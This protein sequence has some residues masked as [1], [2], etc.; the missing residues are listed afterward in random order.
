MATRESPRPG[1]RSTVRTACDRCHETK[2][3]CARAA[4][5]LECE[6]CSRLGNVCIY[7]PPL[8]MGRPK[9]KEVISNTASKEYKNGCPPETRTKRKRHNRA[10][11]TTY[12]SAQLEYDHGRTTSPCSSTSS[13][14]KI[15]LPVVPVEGRTSYAVLYSLL[16]TK[17]IHLTDLTSSI[18]EPWLNA[19]WPSSGLDLDY[20]MHLTASSTSA[21]IDPIAISA[22]AFDQFQGT[23]LDTVPTP[24][25]MN[26]SANGTWGVPSNLINTSEDSF[27]EAIEQHSRRTEDTYNDCLHQLLKLQ[28]DLYQITSCAPNPDSCS[29]PLSANRVS[30][31][32]D[33]PSCVGNAAMSSLDMILSTTQK[34]IDILRGSVPPPK[35]DAQLHD[36]PT[37][38]APGDRPAYTN[39]R[40]ASAEATNMDS[41]HRPDV[42]TTLLILASYSSLLVG[43]ERLV[44]CLI[45]SSSNSSDEPTMQVPNLSPSLNFGTFSMTS[46]STLYIGTLLHVVKQML[47]QLQ[48]TFQTSFSL[49]SNTPPD[50]APINGNVHSGRQSTEMFGD[51]SFNSPILSA[52]QAALTNIEKMEKKLTEVL[53]TR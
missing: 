42:V 40:N 10:A 30:L 13:F 51:S 34:L 52:A 16:C 12:D 41:N 49:P 21:P 24:H 19:G 39:S 4:G 50:V 31:D 37:P 3:R 23:S 46:R 26:T 53:S 7:S 44:D 2:S 22:N 45:L 14:T 17:K 5:C 9:E 1:T 43:Y 27:N 28:S 35:P 18:C 38:T 6:R 15:I 48:N 8:P 32:G 11:Q 25:N 47:E 33:S 20:M 29:R 36:Y